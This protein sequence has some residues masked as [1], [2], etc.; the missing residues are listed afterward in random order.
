MKQPR[1]HTMITDDSIV[2]ASKE[3]VSS[4][5]AGEAVILN[6]DSGVYYGLDAIGARIWNLIQEPHSIQA[7]VEILTREYDVEEDQCRTDLILLLQRLEEEGLVATL[8]AD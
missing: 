7:I 3:Q 4:D 5:L 6:V 8:E 1:E 2:V